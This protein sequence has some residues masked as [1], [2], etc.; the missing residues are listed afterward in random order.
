MR[1]TEKELESIVQQSMERNRLGDALMAE[2]ILAIRD[3]H[4]AV[5]NMDYNFQVRAQQ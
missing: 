1:L 5:V 3:L 4:E 2:A